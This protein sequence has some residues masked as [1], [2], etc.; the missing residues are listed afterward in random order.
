MNILHCHQLSSI[1]VE[2]KPQ[3][4]LNI[5]ARY[6]YVFAAFFRTLNLRI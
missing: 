6:N 2:K 1:Y 3:T 4:N 5:T